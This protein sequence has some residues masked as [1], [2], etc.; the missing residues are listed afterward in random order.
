MHTLVT[1]ADLIR[2]QVPILP[3]EA[4]AIAQQLTH[5]TCT[6]EANAPPGP[7]TAESVAIDEEG[8]VRCRG[9]ASTPSVAELAMLLQALLAGGRVPGG[10]RYAVGRALHDVDAPPFDSLADFSA[11]LKR[12]ENG[13]PYAA[14]RTLAER[15]SATADATAGP[16]A[17]SERRRMTPA[18]SALRRELRLADLRLYEARLAAP[19]RGTARAGARRPSKRTP[20]MACMLAGVSLIAVG[21]LADTRTGSGAT[22]PRAAG[23][24]Q[25]PASFAEPAALAARS[26][27]TASRA[28]APQPTPRATASSAPSVGPV[29]TTPQVRREQARTRQAAQPRQSTRRKAVPQ[30]QADED[31]GVIARIRFEWDNPFKRGH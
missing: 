5:V 23:D 14:V 25:L 13:D 9:F 20:L 1:L 24:V 16:P 8:H 7:L 31:D 18:V 28:T 27:V 17:G 2:R 4:V 22:S 26:D 11:A 29:R 21:E 6:D 15:A 12:F 10:L 3:H 19:P 30:Q